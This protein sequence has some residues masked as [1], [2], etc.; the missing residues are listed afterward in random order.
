MGELYQYIFKAMNYEL[1]QI[2]ET[3]YRKKILTYDDVSEKYL[4]VLKP[5]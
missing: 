3:I 2:T 1:L 4:P 5:L